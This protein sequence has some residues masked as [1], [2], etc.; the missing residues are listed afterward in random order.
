MPQRGASPKPYALGAQAAKRPVM[1][2]EKPAS[3]QPPIIDVSMAVDVEQDASMVDGSAAASQAWREGVPEDALQVDDGLTISIE[4]CIE[5]TD[6]RFMDELTI[7]KP[8]RSTVH[9][10]QLCPRTRRR[11]SSTAR[12]LGASSG[13]DAQQDRDDEEAIP[14]AE[15]AVA[16]AVD[17]PRLDLYTAVAR[18]LTAYIQECKKIYREAEEEALKD[19][20]EQAMLIHHLKLI[21]ANNIGTAK[22]Q[23]YDWKLPWVEQLY[24]SPSQGFTNLES[25]ATYLAGVIK[26]A[27]DILPALRE[28]YAEV[29][30]MLEQE[31]ADIDEMEDSDKD[32]LSELNATIAEQRWVSR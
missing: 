14:L 5:M 22:S 30:P 23:W 17:M 27:Q 21:K 15:F 18:D 24:E 4:Q 6:I 8:R 28:E 13:A 20:T 11:S 9:P 1:H 29:T 2:I 31:Q 10:G 7:H 25:N 12:D 32:Y 19:E 16:M 26:E 3:V